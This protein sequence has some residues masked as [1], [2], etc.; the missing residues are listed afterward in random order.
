MC[1]YVTYIYFYKVWKEEEQEVWHRDLDWILWRSQPELSCGVYEVAYR[2]WCHREAE[3]MSPF[4]IKVWL[5]SSM[6][7]LHGSWPEGTA[8][9]LQLLCWGLIPWVL[10]MAPVP[11]S[12][13]SPTARVGAAALPS[14]LS[15]PQAAQ[16]TALGV[17]DVRIPHPKLPCT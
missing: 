5:K 17:G 1:L 12:Q 10:W 11:L 6:K 13:G 4:C 9:I 2:S 7:W 15:E 3:L 14:L 8:L 16:I